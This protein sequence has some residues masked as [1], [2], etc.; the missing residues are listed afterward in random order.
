MKCIRDDCYAEKQKDYNLD[1]HVSG[2][3]KTDHSVA[4]LLK[5]TGNEL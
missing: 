4:L 1:R 5:V 3:S 2:G